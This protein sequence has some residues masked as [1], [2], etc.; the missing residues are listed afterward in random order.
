MKATY[1]LVMGDLHVGSYY[2]LWPRKYKFHGGEY[3]PNVGQEYLGE[4]WQKILE[5]LRR[6]LS[7]IIFN[8]D[9]IDGKQRKEEGR[10]VILPSPFYQREA[11][12]KVT[13]SIRKKTDKIYVVRGTRY[14]E[15]YDE[16]ESLAKDIGAV[17]GT[18]GIRCRPVARLKIGDIY[19]EARH[20]I[21]G[22]WVYTL[23]ALEREHK[24]DKEA[25]GFKGYSASL[26]I[27]G[28]RHQYRIGGGSGWLAIN[29][30]CMELQTAWAEEAQPNFWVPDLGV[31]LLEVHPDYKD[32]HKQ[33][34]Y[35]HPLLFPHPLPE[36]FQI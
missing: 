14:H 30:P 11:C 13:E 9:L 36:V 19:I 34:I 35:V 32:S 29:N 17:A 15:D 16:M 18:D 2:G 1:G 26:L 24:A 20:K 5:E 31:I 3:I 8:G 23:S 10:G 4:I 21:S 28:H 7:F 6:D 27:G 25:A 22:A 33:P 12:K